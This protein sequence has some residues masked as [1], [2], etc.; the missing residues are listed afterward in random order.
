MNKNLATYTAN[1]QLHYLAHTGQEYIYIFFNV[2]EI[3]R[4]SDIYKSLPFDIM[5][6]KI[7]Y[8]IIFFLIYSC[9]VA[10]YSGQ[11]LKMLIVLGTLFGGRKEGGKHFNVD[12]SFKPKHESLIIKF[13]VSSYKLRDSWLSELEDL[14]SHSFSIPCMNE[15]T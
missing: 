2:A 11:R 13:L 12:Q 8:Y 4:Q 7:I 15:M 5:M 1:W 10:W 9:F 6:V 14:D 3:F